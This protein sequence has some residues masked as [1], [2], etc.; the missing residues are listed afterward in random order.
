MIQNYKCRERE[1]EYA[2]LELRDFC[3]DCQAAR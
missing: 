1:R 3:L 2:E